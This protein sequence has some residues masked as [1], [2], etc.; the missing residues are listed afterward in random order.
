ME[1]DRK[2]KE[3]SGKKSNIREESI[4][5]VISGWFHRLKSKLEKPKE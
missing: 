2:R 5:E 1:S 4:G 3:D